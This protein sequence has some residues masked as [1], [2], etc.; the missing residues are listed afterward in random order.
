MMENTI[1]LSRDLII[2]PGETLQEVIESRGMNQKELA[3]RINM[4]ESFVSKVIKGEKPISNSM[5][6][7]LE[8]ALNIDSRFWANLQSN[9]N[10][11]LEEYKERENISEE[12]LSVIKKIKEIV[13]FAQRIGLISQG[14]DVIAQVIDMRRILNVSRLTNIPKIALS[15]CYRKANDID[16]DIY[17]LFAW[18]KVCELLSESIE[19]KSLLDTEKLKKRIHEIKAVMFQ[20]AEKMQER[21]QEIFS[22]CGIAFCL[23]KNFRG[24]PV[25]GFINK[26]KDGTLMLCMTIRGK[27]ADRFW[28]TLFHEIAHILNGDVIKSMIDFTFSKDDIEERAD[29]DAANMLIPVDDYTNF[30]AMGD[31]SL[32][33]IKKMADRHHVK[34][35]IIIGRLQNEELVPYNYFV[36]EKVRYVWANE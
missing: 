34:P 35:Y 4:S 18:Q 33:A 16:C 8:Y 10:Q 29:A 3:A 20:P 14:E 26:R 27:F 23:T 36:H 19:V 9:Y 24:A 1:G 30:V 28:F 31:F 2:H 15:G 5:A 25:Q 21:L 13:N 11:E 22:E 7:K 32:P 17:I 6:K 12:E